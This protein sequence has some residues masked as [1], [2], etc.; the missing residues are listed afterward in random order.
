MLLHDSIRIADSSSPP[1]HGDV[2]EHGVVVVRP[3]GGADELDPAVEYLPDG[4]AMGVVKNVLEPYR[5]QLATDQLVRELPTAERL[6]GTNLEDGLHNHISRR[7]LDG[8]EQ[9]ERLPVVRRRRRRHGPARCKRPY[10]G[11]GVE[12]QREFRV[13][14]PVSAGVTGTAAATAT[15]LGALA[16]MCTTASAVSTTWRTSPMCTI[17]PPLGICLRP[18][19][20]SVSRRLRTRRRAWWWW[21]SESDVAA[22]VM[23]QVGDVEWAEGSMDTGHGVA[24]WS[25]VVHGSSRG[26]W[27]NAGG[28]VSASGGVGRRQWMREGAAE[29]TVDKRG[30]GKSRAESGGQEEQETGVERGGMVWRISGSD[31]FQ[32]DG[33]GARR[34]ICGGS[35]GATE[36]EQG[37]LDARRRT[38]TG[39]R[40]CRSHSE[41]TRVRGRG[42]WWQARSREWS[43]GARVIH[44]TGVDR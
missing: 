40:T 8:V 11:P 22:A 3:A 28:A 41:P 20:P 14:Q 24:Q 4:R 35:G 2:G 17:R 30:R 16:A 29:E 15:F 26:I 38:P 39:A 23:R 13:T 7:G 37:P 44:V 27:L 6:C 43:R 42:R 1:V 34:R 25:G 32:A 21:E 10:H 31:V 33:L 5:D 36:E 9:E 12:P 19:S 18:G